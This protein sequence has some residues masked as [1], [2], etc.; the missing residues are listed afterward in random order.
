MKSTGKKKIKQG[1]VSLPDNAFNAKE[2]KFRV[3]TYLDL[4][5]LDEVRKRAKKRGLP[6]QTYLNQLLR[7][8]VFGHEIDERIRK[9][10]R[11]ELGKKAD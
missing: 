11:E 8:S 5:I 2:T 7:E 1:A 3:T 10:V 6:Y 4:D 9:I